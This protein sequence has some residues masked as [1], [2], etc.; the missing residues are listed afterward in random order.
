MGFIAFIA[1]W[2]NLISGI[3]E[4]STQNYFYSIYHFLVSTVLFMFMG[5]YFNKLESKIEKL[6]KNN[7][8]TKNSYVMQD[9]IEKYGPVKNNSSKNKKKKN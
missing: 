5:G 3:N 7:I 1:L 6:N 8:A 2:E 9:F 4:F